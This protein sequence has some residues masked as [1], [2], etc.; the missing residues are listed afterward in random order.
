MRLTLTGADVLATLDPP[1]ITQADVAIEDGRIAPPGAV[2]PGTVPP[3]T[4]PLAGSGG[5]AHLDCSG[6]LIVPGNVCAHTH[7][8]SALARGMPYHL[9]APA[10][11]L[12][13]LQRVWWRL[14]RALDPESIRASA[15]AG[16][17]D[18]LLA[19]TTTLVDHHASPNAIDGSLDI[20]AEALAELGLRSVLCYE[21][22][23]R[24]GPERA[25][26]GVTENRRF[27]RRA[28]AGAFPLSRGM[29]GAHASF[30]LSAQTL[31]A[32]V[33]LADDAKT[34]IHLHVAEDGTDGTDARSRFG[35]SVTGRLAAA[36]ALND[37]ALLAHC[38]RLAPEEAAAV[39][40]SGATVAHNC[41][42]NLNNRVGHAPVRSLARLALGTD[43]IDADLF[44][45]S[46]TA[47]L[48]LREDDVTASAGWPL[49][50]LAEGARFAGAA[51]GEPS[52]GT[53]TPGAPADLVVLRYDPPTPLSSANAGGHWAFG[54]HAGLVRD[55]FVA[56]E[57]VV[58]DGTPT[59]VDRQRV[60]A[61][62]RSAAAA[63]WQTADALAPH[64][65]A[66]A[67][68]TEAMTGSRS[69]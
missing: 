8:Y 7:L 65:F 14:D 46:K 67:G 1:Q 43:G 3:G 62:S 39:N 17:L 22:L 51:F 25:A 13:I 52:L 32:C 4:V 29:V 50:R 27:L 36:G 68:G 18:A 30:T 63:L 64:G 11:F 60:L 5:V 34:G 54:L 35:T 55:V 28:A 49:A 66:P 45:E 26:A 16:G 38:V 42:S 59:R 24:D 20:I 2:P 56:G 6:C 57:R 31:A 19:G 69:R 15:L 10:S 48:R 12:E 61:A 44:A 41:R 47:F 58:A 37:R 23:D 33:A 9:P 53:I 40:G 21:V